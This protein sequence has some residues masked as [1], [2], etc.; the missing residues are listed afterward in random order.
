VC[1]LWLLWPYYRKT[2]CNGLNERKRFSTTNHVGIF[3]HMHTVYRIIVEAHICTYSFR[4]VYAMDQHFKVM[5]CFTLL[6]CDL[7]EELRSVTMRGFTRGWLFDNMLFDM[8][9][10]IWLVCRLCRPDCEPPQMGIGWI[11]SM[12]VSINSRNHTSVRCHTCRVLT[13]RSHH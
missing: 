7:L 9:G 4:G 1:N 2:C 10:G 11:N 8:K 5:A 13:N 12:I 6:W 3:S